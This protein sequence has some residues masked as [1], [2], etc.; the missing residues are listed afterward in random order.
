MKKWILYIIISILLIISISSI[1][2]LIISNKD[3]K[4]NRIESIDRLAEIE[5]N[6]INE[7]RQ[8]ITTSY[9]S[10]KVSPDAII[11]FNTY[12][13]VCGHT[14]REEKKAEEDIVNRAEQDITE[15]Y[16][17]W[18]IKKFS[19][20]NVIL[21]KEVDGICDNDYIIKEK[22]GSIAIFKIDNDGRERV[23]DITSIEIQ[24]L[25]E[26][27]LMLLKEGIKV[28]GLDKVNQIIEDFE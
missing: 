4:G 21:Y 3:T 24:Y 23:Y 18:D 10:T 16:I 6:D 7:E 17:D 1:T 14:I 26:T 9:S 15:K 2:L 28:N 8:I 27:D 25:P 5:N 20:D 11:N 22:D 12:Y 19:A 13:K